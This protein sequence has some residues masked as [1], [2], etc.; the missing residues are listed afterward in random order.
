MVGSTVPGCAG[1][2]ASPTDSCLFSRCPRMIRHMM[3]N[4]LVCSMKIRKMNAK[5]ALI[6]K[7]VRLVMSLRM[8]RKKLN[9]NRAEVA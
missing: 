4:Q 7:M 3:R 9:P 8:A 1:S 2:E 5:I 6:W